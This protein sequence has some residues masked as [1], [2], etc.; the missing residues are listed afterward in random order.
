MLGIIERT[1]TDKRKFC[2]YELSTII[3]QA[4][5]M[6]LYGERSRNS[7]QCSQSG[8]PYLSENI[9]RLFGTQGLAHC[10]TMNRVLSNLDFKELDDLKASLVKKLIEKKVIKPIWGYFIFAVDGSEITKYQEELEDCLLHKTSKKTKTTT[11]QNSM[12]EAK[13][14]TEDGLTISVASEPISNTDK[15]DY[16]KQDCELAAAKRML[17]RLKVNFLRLKI[18]I[19]GDALYLNGPFFDLCAQFDWKFL[20]RYKKGCMPAFHTEIIDTAEQDKLKFEKSIPFESRSNKEKTLHKKAYYTGISSLV[21]QG[22]SVTYVE[23]EI[24]QKKKLPLQAKQNKKSGGKPHIEISSQEKNKESPSEDKFLSNLPL[25]EGE[26]TQKDI[27]MLITIGRMRWNI[28]NQ[29]FNAQKNHDYYLKQK[30]VTASVSPLWIYYQI[31]QIAHMINQL[32]E[33]SQVYCKIQKAF[34]LTR[35]AIKEKM[36]KLLTSVY[37]DMDRLRENNKRCQ[38]R[39]E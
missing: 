17:P 36:R 23:A 21:C 3:V 19:I 1:V 18:C 25:S 20:V 5:T 14:I 34:R 30:K 35:T 16:D 39:M 26:M 33:H 38:I 6:Y 2:Y 12:L 24:P 8:N 9:S 31:L 37:L 29:G 22:H 15:V 11:Y 28:E 13:I 10:D 32:F 7:F 4:I 27:F